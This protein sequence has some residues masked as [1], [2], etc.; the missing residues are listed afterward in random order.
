[1]QE[2]AAPSASFKA[3][4]DVEAAVIGHGKVE[5]P[6][7]EIDGIRRRLQDYRRSRPHHKQAYPT[8]IHWE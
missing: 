2:S 4:G 7:T 8:A 6:Y 5:G 1:M 3:D